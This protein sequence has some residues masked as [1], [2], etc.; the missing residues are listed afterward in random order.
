MRQDME[1]RAPGAGSGAESSEVCNTFGIYEMHFANSDVV[2]RTDACCVSEVVATL[3][4]RF[5]H[6]FLWDL[7]VLDAATPVH[8]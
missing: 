3:I 4:L 7:R 5:R 1:A 2:V 8:T 6:Y